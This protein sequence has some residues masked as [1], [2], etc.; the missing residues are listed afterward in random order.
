MSLSDTVKS[1]IADGKTQEAID[2]LQKFLKDKDSTLLNQT[3][4]LEAQYK[5]LMQKI[6][7]GLQD[8]TTEFNRINYSL[9]MIGDDAEKLNTNSAKDTITK[10]IEIEKTDNNPILKPLLL[11]GFFAIIGTALI[12]YLYFKFSGEDDK[13]TNEPNTNIRPKTSKIN[14]P[15]VSSNL[16]EDWDA[17]PNMMLLKENYYGDMSV[18]VKNITVELADANSKSIHLT[19]SYKCLKTS[20]GSCMTNYVIYELV[21]PD[22]S[23]QRPDDENIITDILALNMDTER[24]VI[25]TVPNDLKRCEFRI[26]YI[27]KFA[28]TKRSVKLS[29]SM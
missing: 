14:T 4:L 15:S 6:R 17:V 23:A 19:L 22:F 12:L 24:E 16:K 7:V 21:K 8:S 1:L 18:T 13:P 27:D 26:F 11:F 25:F 20:T 28:Q 29:T 10:T 3:Y 9:L 2:F 5:D